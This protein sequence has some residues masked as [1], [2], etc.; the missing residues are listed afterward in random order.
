[1]P[2]LFVGLTARSPADYHENAQCYPVLTK[3][4][5][6]LGPPHR[7]TLTRKLKEC[8]PLSDPKTPLP[9]PTTP[10]YPTPPLYPTHPPC[11]NHLLLPASLSLSL[12]LSLPLA[13][14]LSRCPFSIRASSGRSFGRRGMAAG[15]LAEA[16]RSPVKPPHRSDDR[17]SRGDD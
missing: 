11:S 17:T 9:Y 14:P 16:R 1:M 10:S 5:P 12:S 6:P 2:I 3:P 7:W 15:V 8:L 13:L 4:G